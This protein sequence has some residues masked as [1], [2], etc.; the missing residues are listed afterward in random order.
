MGPVSCFRYGKSR[1]QFSGVEQVFRVKGM[2]ERLHYLQAFPMI[3]GHPVFLTQTDTMFPAAG[4]TRFQCA[5]YQP[6]IEPLCL[7]S[8]HIVVFRQQDQQVKVAITNV[9][10]FSWLTAK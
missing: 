7:V 1:Q 6:F 4:A 8:R 9:F 5:P 2:F 10:L 3:P